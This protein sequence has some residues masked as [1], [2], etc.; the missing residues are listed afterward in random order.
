MTNLAT[1]LW[2]DPRATAAVE[3]ALVAPLL[4]T[5]MFASV[6]G[7]NYFLN[8]HT[9]IKAV[10]DG[11]RFAARQSF[12][13]YTAC[14]GSPDATNVVTPTKNVVMH[15][16]LSATTFLTPSINASDISVTTSCTTTAGSQTMQGIYRGRSGGAQL[17]TVSATMPYR[18]IIGTAFGFSG[19]GANLNASSQAVVAGI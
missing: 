13:N 10:R 16:Y 15:G 4:L 2:R 8:E 5:I 9:L 6:E 11:A 14:T 1:L 18:S 12:T 19:V 17:V 7:G 3:M